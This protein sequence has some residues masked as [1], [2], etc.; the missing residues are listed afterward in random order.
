LVSQDSIVFPVWKAESHRNGGFDEVGFGTLGGCLKSGG[1]S[2]D[3][4]SFTIRRGGCRTMRQCGAKRIF[5][6]IV[7]AIAQLTQ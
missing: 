2:K 1:A 6:S 5:S 4:A 7:V 3:P